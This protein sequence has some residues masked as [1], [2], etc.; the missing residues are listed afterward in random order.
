MTTWT[1]REGEPVGAW[2][3]KGNQR[4]FDAHSE[5]RDF[6]EIDNWA[7]RSSYRLDLMR[8]GQPALLWI[9]SGGT[10]LPAGF[11][12][13]G[14]ITDPEPQAG[15]GDGLHWRHRPGATTQ[16]TFVGVRLRPLV[17]PITKTE[18]AATGSLG[19][20]ET[21]RAAQLANPNWLLEREYEELS[22]AFDLTTSEPTDLQLA[23]QGIDAAGPV[24]LLTVFAE[25]GAQLS[26]RGEATTGCVSVENTVDPDGNVSKIEDFATLE[27]ALDG[28]SDR[29]ERDAAQS[30][31]ITIE[32][33]RVDL[34]AAFAEVAGG[35]PYLS[36][37][38]TEASTYVVLEADDDRETVLSEHQAAVDAVRAA[39]A[40]EFPYS[41]ELAPPS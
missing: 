10:D 39:L 9:G 6:G 24:E 17:S 5:L 34:L 23:M 15:V 32:P 25:D 1:T 4:T 26:F 16:E 13:A 3:F 8:V 7:V 11:Y 38:R 19:G 37:H 29:I 36:M 27:A 41:D 14:E 21:I 12:A 28:L 30:Q 35:P 31:F 20:I 22:G 33:L 2:V 18:L 40:I